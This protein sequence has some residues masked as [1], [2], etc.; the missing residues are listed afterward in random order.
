MCD[1]L[2]A[3]GNATSDGSVILAKNSDREPNE[4][5]AVIWQP[6]QEH[7]AG[8]M[9]ECTYVRVPQVRETNEVLLCKPFWMWGCEMG[10]NEHGVTIGNEAV[11]TKEAHAET[12]LLGMDMMRLAL[13]RASNAERALE[14]LTDLLSEYGQGGVAGYQNKKMRYHNAFLIADRQQAWE[15]AITSTATSPRSTPASWASLSLSWAS[16]PPAARS[17]TSPMAGPIR[18]PFRRRAAA[19]S[20]GLSPASVATRT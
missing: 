17:A 6:R 4:A 11:F 12:G 13:E 2:V 8:D 14:I 16:S 7:A 19:S 18:R 1:T 5:H 20:S 3:L 9:A 15:P 10:A